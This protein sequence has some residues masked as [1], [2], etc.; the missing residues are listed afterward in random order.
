MDRYIDIQILHNPEI[1]SA[2][3]MNQLFYQL[4]LTLVEN[5]NPVAVSFPDYHVDADNHRNN[6]LGNRLR[7]HG[8]ATALNSLNIQQYLIDI[9][10]YALLGEIKPVPDVVQGYAA[11]VR[12]HSKSPRDID[13]KRQYLLK[14][15]GGEWNDMA[16]KS[17]SRFIEKLRCQLPFIHLVSHSSKPAEDGGK[18]YFHLFINKETGE[19]QQGKLTK[20][21]LSDAQHRTTVPI[22]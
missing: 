18:N 10:N 4:H 21:G 2:L 3:V 15:A 9:S 5:A 6:T 1:A 20:Y 7:L 8:S 19:V 16:E 12:K 11:F 13:R 22:F 17:L 14:K